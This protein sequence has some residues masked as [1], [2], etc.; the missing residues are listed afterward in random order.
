ML[1]DVVNFKTNI[2][3]HLIKINENARKKTLPNVKSILRQ[4]VPNSSAKS[5][6]IWGWMTKRCI[7]KRETRESATVPTQCLWFMVTFYRPLFDKSSRCSRSLA[8]GTNRSKKALTRKVND[9][10]QTKVHMLVDDLFVCFKFFISLLI[11]GG[12]KLTVVTGNGGQNNQ[13]TKKA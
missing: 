8:I 6:D 12:Y 9:Q 3:W 2:F 10:K 13:I 7:K 5:I 11:G 4:T 1:Q